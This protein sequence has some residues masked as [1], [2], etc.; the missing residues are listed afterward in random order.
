MSTLR[1]GHHLENWISDF[2]GIYYIVPGSVIV[3]LGSGG[4]DPG[5]PL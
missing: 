3:G 4:L 5:I 2:Q 1:K